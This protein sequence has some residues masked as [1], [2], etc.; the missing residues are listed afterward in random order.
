VFVAKEEAKNK[1]AK[2]DVILL[3][4]AWFS[5]KSLLCNFSYAF[6]L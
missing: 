5:A 1:H 2:D 3:L 4:H 6:V